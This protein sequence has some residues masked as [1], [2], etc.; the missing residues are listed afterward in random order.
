[1]AATNSAPIILKTKLHKP[2]LQLD[3]VMR[4]HLLQKLHFGLGLAHEPGFPHGPVRKLTLVAAPAGFGK[5]TLV[6]SWLALLESEAAA[7]L[8]SWGSNCWLSLDA[9]DN[10]PGRFLTYVVAAIRSIYPNACEIFSRVLQR[11]PLPSVSY[12]SELLLSELS[13]LPGNL[14]FVLDDYHEVHS[15]DV[16]QVV[17]ALIAH[18]PANFHLVLAMRLDPALPLSRL[19][20]QK[21]I[22]EVRAAELRFSATEANLFFER[23]L[24]APLAEETVHILDERT[25]GWVAGLRL[26]TLALQ[27]GMDPAAL[28]RDFCG[29]QHDILDFLLEQVMAQQPR[30]VAEFL[31][32][33]APLEMLCAPLCDE[34]LDA[35][36]IPL[37]DS[38][39]RFV[40]GGRSS[41]DPLRIDSRAVLDYLDRSHLFVVP[42]DNARQWYRYHPLF[43]DMLLY[44]LQTRHTAEEIKVIN[45][46]AAGWCARNGHV[47]AAVRQLLAAGA[48]EEAADLIEVG[49]P[50]NL[51]RAAWS[52]VQQSLASLPEEIIAERPVLLLARA[53]LM[54]MLQ[55]VDLLPNLLHQAEMRLNVVELEHGEPRPT[56]VQGWIDALWSLIHFLQWDFEA[57]LARCENALALVPSGHVYVRGM[58]T[59]FYV[60]ALHHLGSPHEALAY[61]MHALANEQEETR[62]RIAIAPGALA[63]SRGDLAALVAAGET[64][65]RSAPQRTISKLQGFGNLYLGIAAYEQNNLAVAKGHFESVYQDRFGAPSNLVFDS[66][67]GLALTCQA[68]GD[69]AGAVQWGATLLEFTADLQDSYLMAAAHWFQC[70]LAVQRGAALVMPSGHRWCIGRTSS[71]QY[72]WTELPDLTYAR[73][74]VAQA[75][76]ASLNEAVEL[77]RSMLDRCQRYHLCWRQIEVLAVLA[78][79]LE[80]Q[81]HET[82]ARDTLSMALTLAQPL[83]LVRTFVN[84]G[85]PMA[86]LLHSLARQHMYANQI[87][88]L[89]AEFPLDSRNAIAVAAAEKLDDEIIEPLSEREIEILG[90]LAERLSDKEIATQ[91]RISPLTVRRHSVNLYQKLHVNSRRQAVSRAEAIG[92]LRPTI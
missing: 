82:L 9:R 46:R 91:L 77:L 7:G 1:M 52:A 39:S 47:G 79:A 19:R 73:L 36:I 10:D 84:L 6:S 26:A 67:C 20:V 57:G 43:R 61:C 85:R 40:A 92:L 21:Q 53:W 80:A 51:G 44:W 13:E 28:A 75:S 8:H 24:G 86:Q 83:H 11:L 17:E 58:A 34:V 74:L 33:T 18:A 72:R 70:R 29:T 89:L 63:Q 65:L 68:L 14:I 27:K 12:L 2:Q 31:A 71:L 76:R 49:I 59:I 78:L 45:N 55:R 60:Q 30:C 81:G 41:A 50:A 23:V 25:E 38:D 88:H 16:Q 48:V 69:G 4:A 35:T 87:G 62:Q 15:L 56:W 32:R 3:L 66:L 64:C 90:L 37:E 5:T 54:W 22:T 42:L